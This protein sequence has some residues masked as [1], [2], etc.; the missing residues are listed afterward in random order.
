MTGN[1][2]TQTHIRAATLDDVRGIVDL[3]CQRIERWQTTGA[4]GRAEEVAPHDLNIYARWLHGITMQ[5]APWMTVET[6]AL[7]LSYLIRRRC[8]ALVAEHGGQIVGY[9][10]AYPGDEAPPYGAILHVLH[11]VGDSPQ[12]IAAL[13]DELTACAGKRRLSAT[14]SSY[15]RETAA[16]YGEY[17]LSRFEQ[18]EQYT[19]VAQSGRGFYQATEHHRPHVDQIDGWLMPVGRAQSAATHWHTLWPGIWDALEPI[20]QRRT[21]RLLFHASGQQAMVCIRQQLYTERDAEVF[22]WSPRPL[23]S[24]LLVAIR[25]WSYREGYRTLIFTV[26]AQTAKLFTAD[27]ETTPYKFDIYRTE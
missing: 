19:L 23:S 12:I 16:F 22:C 25:D 7:L 14:A 24:P 6:G 15:D 18:I 9:A 10:E 5:A 8:V 26:T 1:T 3:F 20:R 27:A 21:H 11:L 13:W 4:D 2:T 17:G